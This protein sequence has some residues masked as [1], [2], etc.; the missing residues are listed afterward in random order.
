MKVSTWARTNAATDFL[1]KMKATRNLP[2]VQP[3]TASDRLTPWGIL[4][5]ERPYSRCCYSSSRTVLPYGLWD[6]DIL[7]AWLTGLRTIMASF[8]Q[9]PI[10]DFGQA[11]SRE[12]SASM[13]EMID[14]A[15]GAQFESLG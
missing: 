13:T 14:V 1:L 12:L 5:A 11:L 3:F 8:P 9:S 4:W 2:G 6:A 10:T 15:I 7:R